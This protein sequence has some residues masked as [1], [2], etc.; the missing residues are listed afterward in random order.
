[1]SLNKEKSYIKFP[2][3]LE[4]NF[5]IIGRCKKEKNIIRIEEI[6]KT[7]GAYIQYNKVIINSPNYY[8]IKKS[9][10]AKRTAFRYIKNGDI[11]L[12]PDKDKKIN[13]EVTELPM[14]THEYNRNLE[15]IKIPFN[16][17]TRRKT[18]DSDTEKINISGN[19][20]TTSPQ[21]E[22]VK[23]I[24]F[25]DKENIDKESIVFSEDIESY[26]EII[27][28]LMENYKN[29]KASYS[30][31]NLPDLKNGKN[32]SKLDDKVRLRKYLLSQIIINNK[33]T[34]YLIEVERYGKSLSTLI[35]NPSIHESENMQVIT[36]EILE[37][38]VEKNG[39]WD[40]NIIE[41][42]NNRGFTFN[43][44]KHISIN[45]DIFE[46]AERLYDKI[47]TII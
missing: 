1:M 15:I 5:Y 12:D 10:A 31:D 37:G 16:T 25:K 6:I 26:I 28:K 4:G 24:E 7:S 32:F 27:N 42:Y 20:V 8:K 38:L 3:P 2:F 41:K 30:I 34:I 40:S 21:L 29:I 36:N 33:K 18:E 45:K 35:I 22:K 13:E 44:I 39:V 23:K 9:N 14:A 43:R 17:H 46:L 19:N 47:V 11:I